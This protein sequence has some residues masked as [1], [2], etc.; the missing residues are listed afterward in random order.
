MSVVHLDTH[1]V[2]WLY[3]ALEAK[4]RP[5]LRHLEGKEI[6]ISPMALLEVQYL[7][8]IGRSRAGAAAVFSSLAET[9]GLALTRT[10]W[11]DVV[12]VALGL[13]WTRDPFDR[14]IA[15]TAMVEGALLVTADARLRQH[16]PNAAWG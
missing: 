1:L 13:G 7:H 9:S 10:P 6:A 16:C 15:A 4:F 14:L 12:R 8:E 2:L 3:E 5:A 11:D